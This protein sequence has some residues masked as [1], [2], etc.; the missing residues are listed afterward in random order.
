LG[1]TL[2]VHHVPRMSTAAATMADSLTRASTA[3]VDIWAATTG[4]ATFELPPPLW[5]WLA[6]PHV[7][8]HLGFKL[9]NY[10]KENV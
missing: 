10:L 4:A 5:D 9:V 7:D 3:S 8:W 2:Y 1:C 6:R